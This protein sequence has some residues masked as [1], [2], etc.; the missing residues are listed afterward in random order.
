MKR[1]LSVVAIIIASTV[2]VQGQNTSGILL[3]TSGILL[4]R[5]VIPASSILSLSQREPSGTARSMAMGGAF[6]SLGADMASFGYNPAGFG[7]Y[8]RNEISF[9]LGVGVAH[10]KNYNAYNGN[11]NTNTRVAVNNFGASFKIYESSG[12]LTAINFA[13]GYNKTADYNYDMLYASP[14]TPSSLADAFAD[15]A[16]EGDL[17]INSNNKITDPKGYFDYDMDPYYWGTVM[18]YKAGLINRGSNGW[19]PDEIAP[20]ALMSQYTNLQSRGSAGEFSFAFGFNINNIVYLGA[21]LDIQSISRRQS[22]YYDEYIGYEEGKTPN[23]TDY[24]YQLQSFSFGQS[25][26]VNGSGVGAKFG[27]VVRPIEA[28]RIGFALHTPTYYSIAYRYSASLASTA[29]NAGQI[30]DSAGVVENYFY[31]Y[32]ETPILQD[33]DEYRWTYT[34][35]TRLLAG[36]S[37]SFGQYAVLSAD[38]QYDAYRALKMNYSPAV[39]E[40]DSGDKEPYSGYVNSACRN[41]LKGTHTVRAGVEAKPLPWLSLRVGGGYRSNVLNKNYDF[42]AFSEPVADTMWYASA[43]VGFR[44]NRAISIDLAYQYRNTRYSDYYSFY[45]KLDEDPNAS[46]L[47][48]E[49]PNAS[50]SYGLDL[51]NH[52]IALTFAFRF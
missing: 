7:M 52:N 6:T 18:G 50:P 14:T 24:P 4:N 16:N 11:D 40:N 26:Y 46:Q 35:P 12:T 36:I 21:S 48:D 49:N 29:Y 31:A 39:I 51:I 30:P 47:L 33:S 42:V 19:Y 3:N 38:Y 45:T 44:L 27:V 37:Y 43:G 32:E 13:F 1:F 9:S 20:G 34:T 17:G 5:D 2:A 25:M 41:S 10:A 28:L 15:I 23:T 8:Q 22:I